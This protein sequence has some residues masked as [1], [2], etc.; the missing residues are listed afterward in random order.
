MHRII[1]AFCMIFASF[2]AFSYVEPVYFPPVPENW[3]QEISGI[4]VIYKSKA[5]TNGYSATQVKITY[6]NN[7]QGKDAQTIADEF[8]KS[9][10]C[11][12]PKVE[13]KGF[14]SL[15]CPSI[16]TSAVI[17]GE[18]NNLYQIEISG[19]LSQAGVALIQDYVRKIINGK[20]VFEDRTIG[21]K[22]R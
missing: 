21:S 10:A 11:K 7:T 13:G 1:L 12:T 2:K 8:A 19:E 16:E 22:L 5:D 17:I 4:S 20:L 15:S 18:S 14:F 9:N 3:T 6:T